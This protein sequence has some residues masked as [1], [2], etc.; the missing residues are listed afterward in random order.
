M[1][2]ACCAATLL[3]AQQNI[4]AGEQADK[5]IAQLKQ[6]QAA[7]T[8]KPGAVLKLRVKQGN[9]SSFLGQDNDLQRE[10]EKQTG[11]LV[12]ATAMPQQ[13]SLDYIREAADVDLTIARNH[14]FPDLFERKLIEDLSP[15][16]KRFGFRLPSESGN[17]F[18][19]PVL[20]SQYDQRV[21]AIPADGDLALLFVR[22]DMLDDPTN[23]QRF[24]EQYKRDL[25]PPE[26]WRDYQDLLAFFNNPKE[27]FYG[28]LEPREKLTGWFYWMPRFAAFAGAK[29]GLFDHN[30]RPL[31][32]SAA[33]VA[34]TESYVATVAVSPP[35][36]LGDGKDYSYT[37]PFFMRGKGFSTIV[38]PAG[39][40]IA[41]RPSSAIRGKFSAV[42]MPGQ[43]FGKNLVHRT[44]FIYGNNL[45]IPQKAPNKA[46]AFLYA[47]WITDPDT[48]ARSVAVGNSFQDPYRL[49]H[50]N[51]AAI[52]ELYTPQVLRQIQS[53]LPFAIPSG[54]GLPGDSDYLA[55]LNDNLWAAA[56][57]EISPKE[58][59]AK[60]AAQWESITEKM[61]R[62]KQIAHWKNVQQLYP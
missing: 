13:D 19:S 37:V 11:V 18:F 50:L 51:S 47:M 62:Q 57:K 17:D 42:P 14:E 41:N 7:G 38:T 20:Q 5:A 24:S 8:I 61:G 10:W 3:L 16:Y 33:G 44:L 21:V 15:F 49:G 22:Q 27:G 6:L 1:L 30:M 58:A 56:K 28:A 43:R 45:V 55:A 2:G 23:R 35:E 31:I 46:L 4:H 9:M 26:T 52:R 40:K 39:A 60:T 29:G 54:T 48:S 36:I 34:A 59:M 12:D 32:N 53:E 25:A